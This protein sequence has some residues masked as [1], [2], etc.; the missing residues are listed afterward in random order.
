MSCIEAFRDSIRAPRSKLLGKL[1][2]LTGEQL[3][4]AGWGEQT[5][6]YIQ[7]TCCSILSRSLTQHVACRFLQ[8]FF[9]FLDHEI[10]LVFGLA[11]TLPLLFAHPS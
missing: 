6:H 1:L 9:F 8:V 3:L 5:T 10:H 11:D 2:R 7:N 4:Q